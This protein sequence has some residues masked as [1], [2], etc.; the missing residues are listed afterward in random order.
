LYIN[1]VMGAFRLFIVLILAL[2]FS[3]GG[4]GGNKDEGVT[5]PVFILAGQ[6]N[7]SGYGSTDDLYDPAIN[8]DLRLIEVQHD[9]GIWWSEFKGSVT[10][11]QWI[12]YQPNM[13]RPNQFGPE[14][15]LGRKL[16]DS[17]GEKVYFIKVSQ[18]DTSLTRDWTPD[19]GG[20]KFMYDIFTQEI[21]LALQ[22]LSDAGLKPE[23]RGIFWHQGETD[24]QFDSDDQGSQYENNLRGFIANARSA[25]GD[26]RIPF[27]IGELGAIYPAS[28]FPYRSSVVAAQNA[29]VNGQNPVQD[30][31]LIR[32]S[33]LVLQIED[34]Q[35]VESGVHYNSAG[36]LILGERYADTFL[37]T[38]QAP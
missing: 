26:P 11:H 7:M 36:Y 18:G 3:C 34:Y 10:N 5:V 38:T 32:T 33:D 14:I 24:A 37:T 16:A 12:D 19:G 25:M 17:L 1:Q 28:R 22:T 21:S 2:L 23:I 20:S 31:Y 8:D 15:T 35:G 29:V 13:A 9:V 30:T 27:F 6:S 4:G